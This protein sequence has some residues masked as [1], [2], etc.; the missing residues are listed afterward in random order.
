MRPCARYPVV[1]PNGGIEWVPN[2]RYQR[3]TLA[4]RPPRDYS[5]LGF[6]RGSSLYEQ[7]VQGLDRFAGVANPAL[8]ADLLETLRA[9]NSLIVFRM[10]FRL[11]A[12]SR[13]AIC[14]DAFC[15]R[16]FEAH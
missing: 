5:A 7:A 4:V 9:R 1:I 14:L 15:Y 8:L 6:V 11:G 10:V 3:I 13:A 2:P 12:R 16:E